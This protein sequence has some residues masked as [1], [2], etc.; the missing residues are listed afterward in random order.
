M[1]NF[2]PKRRQFIMTVNEEKLD[3]S[4]WYALTEA[5]KNFAVEYDGMKFYHPD[6]SSFGGFIDLE[7]TWMGIDQFAAFKSPFYV[8]GNQPNFSA[9]IKLK[10]TIVCHQMILDEPIRIEINESIVKLQNKHEKALF[11]LVNLVQPGYFRQ[12][13]AELGNYFGIF[14]NNKLIAVTGER[15]KLDSFTEVSAV[16]THPQHTGKGYAKQ[17]VTHT[18]NKIFNEH[19]TPFLHVA[20]T[21]KGAIKLYEKL[22]FRTRRKIM[23]CHYLPSDGM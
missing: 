7:K 13:T 14:K 6:F 8:L 15:M 19:K 16:V 21:N 4:V 1:I 2:E 17:L 10:N 9:T 3:N 12:K 23:V 11:D 22:G 20:D 5:H 18:T